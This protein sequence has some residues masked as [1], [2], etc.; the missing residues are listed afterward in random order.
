M[1]WPFLYCLERWQNVVMVL[2]WKKGFGF[3]Q[4][5][6]GGILVRQWT[7][8][9]HISQDQHGAR[10]ERL[11]CVALS[12]QHGGENLLSP[13]LLCVKFRP[14][15]RWE[16]CQRFAPVIWRAEVTLFSLSSPKLPP[17]VVSLSLLLPLISVLW[18]KTRLGTRADT[19]VERMGKVQPEW[20][21]REDHSDRPE[22][23]FVLIASREGKQHPVLPRCFLSVFTSFSLDFFSKMNI[24]LFYPSSWII[25][26]IWGEGGGAGR[27]AGDRQASSLTGSGLV[28]RVSCSCLLRPV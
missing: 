22:T 10:G 18:Q 27:Q 28:G 25:C 7:F 23:L 24:T 19:G 2:H 3:C 8:C 12:K 17:P 20:N 6:I 21:V 1:F 5:P 4:W 15:S 14:Q 16:P 11:S 26:S 9:S 13:P